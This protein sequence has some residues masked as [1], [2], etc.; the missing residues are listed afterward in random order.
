MKKQ[1]RLSSLYSHFCFT[2]FSALLISRAAWAYDHI[3][4]RS[5][6]D[7]FQIE[8]RQGQFYIENQKVQLGPLE[9]FI[10]SFNKEVGDPCPTPAPQF[11]LTI[12]LVTKEESELSPDRKTIRKFSFA[13]KLLTDGEGCAVVHG[14]GVYYLPLHR[15]WYDAAPSKLPL[16]NDFRLRVDGMLVAHFE[17]VN[18]IW[19]D[20]RDDQYVDWHFFER[21][22]T[23][24]DQHSVDHRLATEALE[25]R[26]TFEVTS[27]RHRYQ[28]ARVDSKLWAVKAPGSKWL[29]ASSDWTFLE[30][31]QEA[32][33]KDRFAPVLKEILNSELSTSDRVTKLRS[34]SESW[35]PTIRQTLH[36]IV[37]NS[38]K[39]MEL[40]L[41]AI[42]FLRKKPSAINMAILIEALK[43]N[44]ELEVL[45]K[46]THALRVVHPKGPLIEEE[47]DEYQR[48]KHI[49]AWQNWW[50]TEGSKAK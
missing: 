30:D 40:R 27:G 19:Q 28:F 24:F 12:K 45:S 48:Q 32:Q 16:G 14:R 37:L 31:M 9:D 41:A 6:F 23:T 11:P 15:S 29:T 13:P 17:K 3:E 4:V 49:A 43:R 25:G 26:R 36:R 35:S 21:F 33:W 10:K 39:P 38:S 42:E 20:A 22:L 47:S 2:L 50:K 18:S 8:K 5:K 34:L 7:R 46:I 1:Q 44:S